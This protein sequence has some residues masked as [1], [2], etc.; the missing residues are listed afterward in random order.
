MA[1]FEMP[2][3]KDSDGN[4][5]YFTDQ[6]AR[7]QLNSMS[8]IMNVI[9]IPY[10]TDTL[11][12]IKTAFENGTIPANVTGFTIG[13]IDSVYGMSRVVFVAQ[14]QTYDSSHTRY[15][16]IYFGAFQPPHYCYKQDGAA[17]VDTAL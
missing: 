12:S 2:N 11:T 8:D 1:N 17:W 3:F 5:G 15:A 16:A 9:R 7:A 4:I 13:A 10:V 14:N 6:A